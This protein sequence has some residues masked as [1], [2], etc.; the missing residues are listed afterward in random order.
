MSAAV[1][2]S[3]YSRFL[4]AGPI[5]MVLGGLLTVGGIVG[6]TASTDGGNQ[7]CPSGTVLIAKFNYDHGYKFEKPS[8]NQQVVTLSN[9]SAHGATW[10]S[11]LPVS[12]VIVKGGPN[13]VLYTIAPPKSDGTFSNQGLPKVGH[14][15]N[16]PD[17]SNVQFCGSAGVPTSTSSSTSTSTS[18]SHPTSTTCDEC[19]TTTHAPV[20]TTCGECQTTTTH[21]PVTTTCGECQTTTTH[22]P[23]TTTCGQCQTTTTH[24]PVTTTCECVT[25]TTH[26]TTTTLGET[27]TIPDGSTTSSSQVAGTTI[28]GATTT[29]TRTHHVTTT[30]SK[31]GA[32]GG[33]T[34]FK[35]YV[36]STS[37]LT[38]NNG[39]ELPFTGSGSMPLVALGIVLLATGLTLTLSQ[40]RRRERSRA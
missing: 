24:A 25:T 22:A 30:T 29:T 20:T 19:T 31:S 23:V 2:S 11:S 4:R 38:P 14:E 6:T 15:K 26:H 39:N 5:M 21:A 3:R 33:T 34:T 40:A 27:T 10:H 12:Y 17:V 7:S 18:T 9:A 28:V 13:S 8:G 35:P 37:I 32:Q 1:S 16:T 36:T